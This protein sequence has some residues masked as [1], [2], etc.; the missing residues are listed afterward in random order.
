MK[1]IISIISVAIA[2]V[3]ML[4]SCKGSLSI[5]L[6]DYNYKVNEQFSLYTGISVHNDFDGVVN[7]TDNSKWT[8]IISDEVAANMERSG[9]FVKVTAPCSGTVQAIYDRKTTENPNGKDIHSNV[10]YIRITK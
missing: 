5:T 8:F 1:R 10:S 2:A 3:C 9:S 6:S 7:V 4:A